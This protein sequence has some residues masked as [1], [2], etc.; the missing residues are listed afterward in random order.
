MPSSSTSNLLVLITFGWWVFLPYDSKGIWKLGKYGLDFDRSQ[1]EQ[2]AFYRRTIP[3][4]TIED[5]IGSPYA[6][7]EFTCNPDLGTDEDILA[8]KHKLNGMGMKLMLDFVPNHSAVDSPL[9]ASHIDY[10]IRAPK[11]S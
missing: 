10:Y 11:G 8:L 6:V 9:T 5:V 3:D 2:I 4:F 1:Q 7:S